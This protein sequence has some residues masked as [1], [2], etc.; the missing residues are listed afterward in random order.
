[1]SVVRTAQYAPVLDSQG[2]LTNPSTNDVAADTGVISLPGQYEV[3]VTIGATVA[4][5][6]SFQ[7]R[8][9]G[10]SANLDDVAVVYVPATASGQYLFEVSINNAS[11]R[12]RVLVTAGVTGDV[13]AFISAKKVA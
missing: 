3:R 12:C 1:M 10:N 4:T 5:V 6:F 8:N 9:A 13:A 11:E 7:H 2:I